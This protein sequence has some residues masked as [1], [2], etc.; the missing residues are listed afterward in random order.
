ML[1][2]GW[3]ESTVLGCESPCGCWLVSSIRLACS[4]GPPWWPDF[5]SWGLATPLPSHLP[6]RTCG[7][8]SPQVQ[9]IEHF[10]VRVS[11]FPRGK[12]IHRSSV[13]FEWLGLNAHCV[14]SPLPRLTDTDPQGS[15]VL[16]SGP[17]LPGTGLTGTGTMTVV[18][19]SICPETTSSS[20]SLFASTKS[21]WGF[22]LVANFL[23]L[24]E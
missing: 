23:K 4:A 8:D 14:D 7:C 16:P 3:R 18:K 21:L 17:A 10:K 2:V 20:S 19:G 24:R 6:T 11:A 15:Y 13:F 9:Y 1:P 12:A 22:A 5:Q